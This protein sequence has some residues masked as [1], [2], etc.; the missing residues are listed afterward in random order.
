M[1]FGIL[2][3]FLNRLH[4]HGHIDQLPDMETLHRQ[5]EVEDG[6]Y[7]QLTHKVVEEERPPMI[8]IEAYRSKRGLA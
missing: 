8:E 5:F 7:R 4:S 2:Q 6:H 3:T 1:S